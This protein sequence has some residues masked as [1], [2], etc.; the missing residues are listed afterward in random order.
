MFRWTHE[1]AH[2]RSDEEITQGDTFNP[3]DAE[4]RAFGDRMVEV[5]GLDAPVDPGEFSVRE[6]REHIRESS[7]SAEQRAALARA[8]RT[9][10]GR[11]SAVDIL[12]P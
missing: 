3:T 10:K 6:L 1:K 7:Y 9:G 4:K 11:S 5:E 12:E 8:E 2:S